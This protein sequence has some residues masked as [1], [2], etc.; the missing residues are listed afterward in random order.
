MPITGHDPDHSSP[1]DIRIPSFHLKHLLQ[2]TRKF[3]KYTLPPVF[4]T[5]MFDIFLV[6][7]MQVT[8]QTISSFLNK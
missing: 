5:K 2:S 8:C 7:I 3:T 4:Q 1:V 6:S